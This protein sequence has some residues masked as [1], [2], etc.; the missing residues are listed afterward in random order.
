M[1]YFAL[2]EAKTNVDATRVLS[3][4]E[5]VRLLF[6]ICSEGSESGHKVIFEPVSIW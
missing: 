3:N 1:R 5:A 4:I 2:L 6:F